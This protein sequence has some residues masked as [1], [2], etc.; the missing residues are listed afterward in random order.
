MQKL[1]HVYDHIISIENLL[2]AWREFIRG[3]RHKLDT[4]QFSFRLM[5]N[6]LTLHHDLQTSAY[7]HGSYQTF[8]INDPKPRIINKAT[9]RDRLVHRAVYRQ[10]YWFFHQRFIYDSYSCQ[11]GKGTHKA[12]NHFRALTYEVSQNH[13]KTCWVLK[14]DI[15]KFFASIDHQILKSILAP[16]FN[17]QDTVNL[18]AKIIDSFHTAPNVGLPLGNLTSQLLSNIYLN[19][20]DQFIKHELKVKHYIRYA[21]DFVILSQNKPR[22]E[23]LLTSIASFLETNLRLQLH[24]DKIFLQTI[25]AGVDFL[26]W[27]HFSDHRV[28]RTRTKR[29]MWRKLKEI[30]SKLVR[31]QSYLGMLGWGN[32]H[33]LQEYLSRIQQPAA[34]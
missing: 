25:A 28:L 9:V 1:V 20:F 2:G 31:I 34:D 22:L 7:H 14:C 15:K 26:G 11:L 17:D 16:H 18:L 5:D 24:H 23:N 21:D 33:K 8:K 13:T 19:Q 10:L 4:Q 27:V 6:L 29:R 32:S 3:K 30:P 12:L